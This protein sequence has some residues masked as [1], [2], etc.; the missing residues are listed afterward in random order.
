M[1]KILNKTISKLPVVTNNNYIIFTT[2]YLHFKYIQSLLHTNL[3]NHLI[4]ML[5]PSYVIFQISHTHT[6]NGH[7]VSSEKENQRHVSIVQIS[8]Q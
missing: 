1:T 5:I 4:M 3:P 8:N 2:Y 6:F 7:L